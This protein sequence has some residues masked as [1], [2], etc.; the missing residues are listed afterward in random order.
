MKSD[1]ICLQ[2]T[3]LEDDTATELFEIPNYKLHL[4]SN[5]KGKGIAIY[6]KKDKIRHVIDIKEENMQLSK[7]TSDVIDLAVLYRSQNGSHSALIEIL[8]T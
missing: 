5:G 8:E 1:A 4:N 3:W 6:F 7:F 2:E